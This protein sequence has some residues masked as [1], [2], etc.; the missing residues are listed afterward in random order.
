[1][2]NVNFVRGMLANHAMDELWNKTRK[3]YNTFGFDGA[4]MY[5][6]M[7]MQFLNEINEINEIEESR[8]GE[9]YGD[10]L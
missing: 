3:L 7:Q 6:E 4:A 5:L 10:K 2:D 1:M 8:G 9:D